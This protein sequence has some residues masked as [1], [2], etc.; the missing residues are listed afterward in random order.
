MRRRSIELS[1]LNENEAAE[2]V[3]PQP[4]CSDISSAR[5][6]NHESD[7]VNDINNFDDNNNTESK[8]INTY[9]KVDPPEYFPEVDIS[10]LSEVLPLSDE[11]SDMG[12]DFSS[13]PVDWRPESPFSSIYMM[14]PVYGDS[15]SMHDNMDFWSDLFSR[16]E[17]PFEL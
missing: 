8:E 5:S 1:K 6:Y 16:A 12:H 2:E 3:S 13:L 17:E 10:F 15:S 11:N 7:N 14:E 4:S 9:E